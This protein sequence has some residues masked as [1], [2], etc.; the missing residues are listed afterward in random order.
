MAAEPSEV[1][2]LALVKD[3]GKSFYINGDGSTKLAAKINAPTD[4]FIESSKSALVN[5]QLYIFGG[6]I[7]SDKKRV[8][9]L[10]RFPRFLHSDRAT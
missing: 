9:I 3:L 6:N 8:P 5:G 10:M 2:I 4:F 7:P 1:S